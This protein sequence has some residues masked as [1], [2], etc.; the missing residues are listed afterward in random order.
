MSYINFSKIIVSILLKYLETFAS[1][2]IVSLYLG[3]LFKTKHFFNKN[4]V[5]K[6][7]RY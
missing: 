4:T 5:K 2:V 7:I 6:K 1:I 3:K